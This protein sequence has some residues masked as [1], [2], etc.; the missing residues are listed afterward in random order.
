MRKVFIGYNANVELK[1]DGV[2]INPGFMGG[3][4]DTDIKLI[5]FKDI[6]VVEFKRAIPIIGTGYIQFVTKS[7]PDEIDAYNMRADAEEWNLVRF[8]AFSN[9]MF[10]E[11]YD[12]LIKKI[13]SN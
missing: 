1:P 3:K 13:E 12:F 4:E 5:K 10:K 6:E 8:Q 11:L 7:I 9:I 2:E